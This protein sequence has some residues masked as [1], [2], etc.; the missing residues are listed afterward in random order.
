MF[1]H[2]NTGTDLFLCPF[3]KVKFPN[4]QKVK[5]SCQQTV[6]KK[7]TFDDFGKR[8]KE[9]DKVAVFVNTLK[10]CSLMLVHNWTRVPHPPTQKPLCEYIKYCHSGRLKEHHR[11]TSS[12]QESVCVCVCA[13]PMVQD[14]KGW[15]KP[16][17]RGRDEGGYIAWKKPST[18]VHE[19]TFIQDNSRVPSG[20]KTQ[21]SSK[22][23][24]ILVMI[25]THNISSNSI[26]HC[27][28]NK[29]KVRS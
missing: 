1:V 21:L 2:N 8:Q 15:Q 11:N 9:R 5:C 13:A 12:Q 3:K 29:K 16:S 10:E 18:S 17:G 7:S 22:H 26:P 4:K 14:G 23:Q 25:K 28:N 6:Y 20:E 19:C 27:F 24:R